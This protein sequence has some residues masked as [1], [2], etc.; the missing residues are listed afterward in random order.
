MTYL[1]NVKKALPLLWLERCHLWLHL[2]INLDYCSYVSESLPCLT[3]NRRFC[4]GLKV[5]WGGNVGI[6]LKEHA[7]FQLCGC[8]A[9][10]KSD[11]RVE[12]W[13]PTSCRWALS[14]QRKLCGMGYHSEDRTGFHTLSS[15]H[16]STKKEP[17]LS[18][19]R[20]CE[21]FLR[22]LLFIAFVPEI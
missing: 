5:L 9:F 11:G 6:R 7:L 22:V 13:V 16:W 18:V 14:G 12:M 1:A 8:C 4:L 15:K 19:L 2:K 17:L 21:L 10:G 20:K 3:N